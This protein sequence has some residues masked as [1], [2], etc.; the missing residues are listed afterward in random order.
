MA[1]LS[2]QYLVKHDP[3]TGRWNV[4]RDG[5][6]TGAFGRDMNVAIGL[7]T[8]DA[9]LEAHQSDLKV[10]VWLDDGKKKPQKVWPDGL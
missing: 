3:D 6:A 7:A 2:V 4:Y 10:T 8:R 1:G 5:K 9:S